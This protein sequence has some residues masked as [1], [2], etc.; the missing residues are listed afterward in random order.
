MREWALEVRILTVN[1]MDSS[2]K[3]IVDGG[4]HNVADSGELL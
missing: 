3:S 1:Q 2:A 4:E